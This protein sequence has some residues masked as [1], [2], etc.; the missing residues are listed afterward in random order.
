[1]LALSFWEPVARVLG[2]DGLLSERMRVFPAPL[3]T[4]MIFFCFFSIVTV[5]REA[6]K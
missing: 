6:K 2:H 4:G 5:V 1:M 3:P